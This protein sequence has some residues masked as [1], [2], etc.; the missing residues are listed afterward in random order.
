MTNAA[1]PKDRSTSVLSQKR[2][3]TSGPTKLTSLAEPMMFNDESAKVPGHKW[4]CGRKAAVWTIFS[5]MICGRFIVLGSRSDFGTMLPLPVRPSIRIQSIGDHLDIRSLQ[6]P[7]N[8]GIVRS[9]CEPI[10]TASSPPRTGELG[11]ACIRHR[12]RGRVVIG[13]RCPTTARDKRPL[14]PHA[15]LL[16]CEQIC[17]GFGTVLK[18]INADR[19]ECRHQ[20]GVHTFSCHLSCGAAGYPSAPIEPDDQRRDSAESPAL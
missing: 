16:E 2:M 3:K 15:D 1:T 6:S 14:S 9:D 18:P 10:R 20:G 11:G 13:H 19:R 12:R 17:G 7:T 8:K 5:A 4:C